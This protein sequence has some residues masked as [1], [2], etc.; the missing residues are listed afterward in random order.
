MRW[1]AL[2]ALAVV[3]LPASACAATLVAEVVG[4]DTDVGTELRTQRVPFAFLDANG[5]G[6]LDTAQPREPVYLDVDGSGAVSYGDVRITPFGAYASNTQV[7]VANAD[8]GRPLVAAPG[9]FARGN[10]GWVADLDNSGT[11]TIGDVRFTADGPM[12][13][14]GAQATG[15]TLRVQGNAGTL[16]TGSLAR[17]LYLDVDQ[18]SGGGRVSAGD[19]RIVPGPMA[20]DAAPAA[21]AANP[22]VPGQTTTVTG[23]ATTPAGKSAPDSW[24]PLDWVLVALAVANLA[25]LA[26]LARAQRPKN[27]FH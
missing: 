26:I 19:L 22:A 23:A 10:S 3:L 7:D 27:P 20:S 13:V 8:A 5:N 11:V 4:S 12:Q 18:N 2:F 24:R 17:T 25:G 1:T 16:A 9:W 21:P 6:H 14:D 15:E